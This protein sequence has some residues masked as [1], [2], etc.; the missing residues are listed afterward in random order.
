MTPKT[1]LPNS[2]LADTDLIVVGAGPAGL[3]AATVAA[4]AGLAVTL[5]DEQAT[6]GGQIY[7]SVGRSDAARLAVLGPDYAA[8]RALLDGLAAPKLDHRAGATVWEVT[9]DRRVFFS[10]DGSGQALQA[11]Q[12][13]LCTGA[14]ERPMP[15]PGWTLPGVM[16]A[17][18]A[19]ILLKASGLLPATPPVLAGS[20]PLLYLLAVQL[21]RAEH[22]VA[23]LVETTPTGNRRAALKHL[24][25]ALRAPGIL[26]KGLA[27]L[28]ELRRH[29]VPHIKQAQALRAEGREHLES[30]TFTVAGVQQTFPCR[31]LLIHNGVVPN[32]Q[33]TRSLGLEHDWDGL[34]RCWRPR[35]DDW[36]GTTLDGIAVAGDGAGIAGAEAAVSAGRLAGLQA[37]ACLGAITETERDRRAAPERR[38]L[39]GHRRPRP[40][41]D[42]LYAPAR[43]FLVPDDETLVCRCEEVTAG[44]IR[45]YVKLGCLGPNQTKAFGRPGMGPCQGRFC[46]LTVS[47]VIADARGLP[48]ETV[49]SYR[50]R[51]P[52]KPV[53]LGELAAAAPV[54]D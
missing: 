46:G 15:F 8:G 6:P 23:A 44:A 35:L 29:G 20:G 9:R 34:Q 18:A 17:G 38:R 5:L 16:T 10:Q 14:L 2:D 19:Q 1:E 22:P 51:T 36:G 52:I 43:A 40:F 25:A 50:V 11:R 49:G 53:T 31:A 33:M 48:V 54:E 12:V 3:A 28:A 45:D 32:L 21:L 47:E 30:L 39:A 13:I 7:R 4:E 41:L 26:R 42:A 24:P 27:L 37:A